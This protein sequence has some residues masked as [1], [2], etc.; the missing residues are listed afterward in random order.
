MAIQRSTSIKAIE[1]TKLVFESIQGGLGLLKFVVES[2]APT[3]EITD[4]EPQKWNVICSFFET[5]YSSTPSRY[6]VSVD[7][8]KNIV[9]SI[10]RLNKDYSFFGNTYQI[11]K[12]R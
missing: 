12:I 10:E 7:L 5:F 8:E 9:S 3:D 1:L 2:L 4:K 6:K 11:T